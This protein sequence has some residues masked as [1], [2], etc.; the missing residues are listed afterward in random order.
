MKDTLT[1]IALYFFLFGSLFLLLISAFYKRRD[2]EK[3]RQIHYQ[4]ELLDSMRFQVRE[5]SEEILNLRKS[6]VSLYKDS[7]Q[8]IGYLIER[9]LMLKDDE[10]AK[11]E[12]HDRAQ[13]K[14]TLFLSHEKQKE[15]ERI[16]NDKTDHLL[17]KIRTE[18]PNLSEKDIQFL[19]FLLLGFDSSLISMILNVSQNSLYV[20]KSRLKE[21]ILIEGSPN[22][23]LYKVW[24]F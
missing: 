3:Q 15:R 17:D 7:F 21:K 10:K 24:L 13:E 22:Y 12:Y 9:S 14:I 8:E 2:R 19:S 20:R 11:K 1:L 16:I 23:H 4:Q 6:C 18:F 5:L